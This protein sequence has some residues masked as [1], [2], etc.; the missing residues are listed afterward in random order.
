MSKLKPKVLDF[1]T[2][3]KTLISTGLIHFTPLPAMFSIHLLASLP[4]LDVICLCNFPAGS[5]AIS[6]LVS[7]C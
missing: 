1:K 2:G 7:K 3:V 5:A 4:V 6:V